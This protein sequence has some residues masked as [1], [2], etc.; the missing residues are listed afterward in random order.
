MRDVSKL[1]SVH[2]LDLRGCEAVMDTS[3]LGNVR[4]LLLRWEDQEP[5]GRYWLD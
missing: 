2:T 5:E 4:N 3:A 1:G